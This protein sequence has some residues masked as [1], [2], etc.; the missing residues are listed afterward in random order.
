MD[1]AKND[2]SWD[3][4]QQKLDASFLQSTAWEE[5]QQSLG[6]KVHK[7]DEAD[8]SCL[9]IEQHSRTR[10]YL[11]APYG[12]T[13]VSR[14]ILPEAL[15]KIAEF[16]RQQKVH[17]VRIEPCLG[18]STDSNFSDVLKK[19]TG[20][21]VVKAHKQIDPLFTRILDL[22]PD[23]QNILATISS[24]TR[25][26]IR[27][28]TREPVL[29]FKTSTDPSDMQLL[30][31]M[32]QTVSTRNNVFFHPKE[33]FL[34]E[35]ELLMPRGEMRLE[36]ALKDN[37]PI[38]CIAMNDFNNVTT[39]TYAASLP[40]ARQ[41]SASALLLWQAII[42]AK[43]RG[44]TRLDLF[45]VAPDDASPS[46][47][48]YGFTAFKKKFDGVTVHRGQTLDIPLSPRYYLYRAAVKAI[49]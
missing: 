10:R 46:H 43:D 34:K 44:M 23:E 21:K 49:R 38:A 5:F 20:T 4:H 30:I 6:H 17:W 12:P 16:G 40:E 19:N 28:H 7:I 29:E 9:L 41:F 1:I 31:D 13:L 22:T 27:K 26:L 33:Y 8:W 14:E 2:N 32:L 37:Q 48:W 45:G 36:F 35:A 39:Y 11:F 18:L 15:K 42:N 25:S 47:P 24:S 3:A